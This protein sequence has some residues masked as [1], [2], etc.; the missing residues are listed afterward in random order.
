MYRTYT[1]SGNRLMAFNPNS[2]RFNTAPK[3]KVYTDIGNQ[4][5]PDNEKL[6]K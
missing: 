1:D 4:D 5:I 3:L 6:P 2:I